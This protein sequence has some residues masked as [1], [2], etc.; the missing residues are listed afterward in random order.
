MSNGIPDKFL[1]KLKPG[2]TITTLFQACYLK[3]EINLQEIEMDTFKITDQIIMEDTDLGDCNLA[4]IFSMDDVQGN[5]A[6][7]KIAMITVE[8]GK[9]SIT[10]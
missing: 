10:N 1:I 9:I 3:D 2:D 4:Y 7:S 8:N 5:N 6:L